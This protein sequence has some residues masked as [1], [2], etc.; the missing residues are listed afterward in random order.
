MNTAF[1]LLSGILILATLVPLSPSQHW[2]VRV[3]DFAKLQFFW[4]QVLT[5]I[6]FVR[7]PSNNR[8][9]VVYGLLLLCALYNGSVL[10]RYTSLYRLPP[11]RKSFGKSESLVLVSANVLQFNTEYERFVELIKKVQ[12]DLFL[13]MESNED[14]DTAMRVLENDYPF[15][16]KIPL[17]NT[18]GMHLYSK[19]PLTFNTHYFVADDLP[20]IE[21]IG[22]ASKGYRFRL[23][24]VHPPPP[25]PTEEDTS[26]ERDGE[27]LSVAKDIKEK[28]GTNL[29]VGDFNNV[30][31]SRSSVLFRKLSETIDPRIGR[32]FAA[33]FHAKYP[34]ARFPID[35]IFHTPDIFVE[36]LKTLPY[37]GSDHLALYLRFH[38]NRFNEEQ[39]ELVEEL[40]EGEMKEVEEMIEEG[41]EEEGNRDEVAEP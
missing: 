35:Q 18:Y 20:S 26:K 41:I 7:F 25:S 30:A 8:E 24:C 6:L 11:G 3:F 37:F 38:I 21:A 29:V 1:H 40:E 19:F 15:F 12:P 31:W 14:W 17:E 10:V 13:T 27:L 32:G 28:G 4:L 5:L 34:F 22:E 36:E 9:W 16:R 23:F 2:S 33:T 39:E